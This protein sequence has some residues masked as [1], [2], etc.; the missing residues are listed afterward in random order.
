ML[1]QLYYIPCCSGQPYDSIL[2]GPINGRDGVV[3]NPNSMHESSDVEM[4][5]NIWY[6]Y[7]RH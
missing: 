2:N 7:F 3:D 1:G 5:A 4:Q 6:S